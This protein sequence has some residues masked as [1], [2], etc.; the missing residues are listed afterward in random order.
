MQW[1]VVNPLEVLFGSPVL[2]GENVLDYILIHFPAL[3]PGLLC[4]VVPCSAL[5]NVLSFSLSSVASFKVDVGEYAFLWN[6]AGFY[7]TSYP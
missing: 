3:I 1:I 5:F 6:R 7:P 4:S 2:R